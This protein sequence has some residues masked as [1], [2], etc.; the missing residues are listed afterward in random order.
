MTLSVH[1]G[2]EALPPKGVFDWHYLQCV[3][4]RFATQ[5]YKDV[6]GIYFSVYPFKTSDCDLD[7]EFESEDHNG[8]G[9]SFYLLFPW[10]FIAYWCWRIF[11]SLYTTS[12]RLLYHTPRNLLPPPE[13]T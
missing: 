8:P 10:L 3:A 2:S 11:F 5:E 1:G 12:L 4:K 9:I 13:R 7:E 6:P